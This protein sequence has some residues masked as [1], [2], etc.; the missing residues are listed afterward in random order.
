[1]DNKIKLYLESAES[2]S[3]K[4]F[5]GVRSDSV[6][7]VSKSGLN[8]GLILDGLDAHRIE[9]GHSHAKDRAALAEEVVDVRVG[10]R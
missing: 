9:D 5:G 2:V 10:Q 6:S 7:A 3:S 1:M 8:N 4:P